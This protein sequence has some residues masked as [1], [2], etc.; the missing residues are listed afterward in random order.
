MHCFVIYL[1]RCLTT[2]DLVKVAWVIHL[3]LAISS[4]SLENPVPLRGA[5]STVDPR[6]FRTSLCRSMLWASGRE[7][8]CIMRLMEPLIHS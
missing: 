5:L 1:S 3:S 4:D 2:Y 7:A 8:D 6:K